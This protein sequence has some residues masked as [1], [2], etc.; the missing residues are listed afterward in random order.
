MK[1]NCGECFDQ[2][3]DDKLTAA[4]NEAHTLVS[5]NQPDRPME[6]EAG[7]LNTLIKRFN[8]QRQSIGT[9]MTG[10][11]DQKES[12][13][14]ER[15]AWDGE[16]KGYERVIMMLVERVRDDNETA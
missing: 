13:I 16:R 15:K 1:K 7:L 6:I 10:L 4:H 14:R 9:L 2:E 3:F 11:S 8:R 12:A 5:K